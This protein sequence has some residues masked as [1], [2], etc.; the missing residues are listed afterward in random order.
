MGSRKAAEID[1]P[2]RRDDGQHPHDAHDALMTTRRR[3]R[4]RLRWLKAYRQQAP[5]G[6][7]QSPNKMAKSTDRKAW[8]ND[9][10]QFHTGLAT[11]IIIPGEGE[12]GDLAPKKS[13][14]KGSQKEGFGPT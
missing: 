10:T 13:L 12:M 11:P 4:R 14:G 9:G 5:R 3:A 7:N 1:Y 8:I 2:K 6:A